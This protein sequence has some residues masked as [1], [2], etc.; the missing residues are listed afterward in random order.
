M[1]WAGPIARS[2][3]GTWVNAILSNPIASEQLVAQCQHGS[4]QAL[5]TLVAE[6]EERIFN[7]LFHFVGNREDAEDLTQDTFIKAFKA[8]DRIDPACHLAAWL[9]TI[10]KRTAIN[11]FRTR[12]TV[13]LE[14]WDQEVD[15][16]DPAAVAA[17]KEDC[18]SIWAAARVL[19]K[20]Q[21]EALWLRYGEGFSIAETARIMNTNQIRVR[22]LLH[23]GRSHLAKILGRTDLVVK[24][25]PAEPWDN[26]RPTK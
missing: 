8:L 15:H 25:R 20:D 23:R 18:E 5:E 10:A 3:F 22:V 1:V 17:R 2:F 11:H 26:Q 19:K 4:R 14:E 24:D 21:F 16:N 12:R 7:Y 13:P 9:F 6:Y